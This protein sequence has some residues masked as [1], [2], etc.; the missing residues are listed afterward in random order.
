MQILSLPLSLSLSLS[1]YIYIY[2][3]TQL[4]PLGFKLQVLGAGF[5]RDKLLLLIDTTLTQTH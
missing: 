4:V 1:I 2:S 5:K 3:A